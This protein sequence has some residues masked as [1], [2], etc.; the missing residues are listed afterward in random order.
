MLLFYYEEKKNFKK[1]YK[2]H[3]YILITLIKNSYAHQLLIIFCRPALSKEFWETSEIKESYIS[4]HLRYICIVLMNKKEI[5]ILI[6]IF[7]WSL[8]EK[9]KMRNKNI[10]MIFSTDN[11]PIIKWNLW[12]RS[13]LGQWGKSKDTVL[14]KNTTRDYKPILYR[15]MG[16]NASIF[17]SLL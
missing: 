6:I 3:V 8:Y 13:Q 11:R 16:M 2:L 14:S 12:D 5:I 15:L 9:K 4:S 7:K 1:K 10:C 17:F